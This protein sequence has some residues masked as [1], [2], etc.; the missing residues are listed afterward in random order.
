MSNADFKWHACLQGALVIVH[1]SVLCTQFPAAVWLLFQSLTRPWLLLLISCP[2][3]P[4]I[5]STN[6]IVKLVRAIRK[7]WISTGKAKR[8]QQQQRQQVYLLWG[9]DDQVSK[10]YTHDL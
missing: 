4:G 9:D 10:K 6:R 3:L 8:A 5:R 2:V 7:G 1:V